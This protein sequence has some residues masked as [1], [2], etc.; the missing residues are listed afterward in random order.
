MA[1]NTGAA[2]EL[3]ASLRQL[4]AD[5]N[6]TT[7]AL[8]ERA[9]ISAANISNYETAAR[10]PSEER[11]EQ[12][13]DALGSN[14]DERE[15][16]LG[17]L[18]KAQ[19]PGNLVPGGTVIG[20]N[21]RQTIDYEENAREII[22]FE[23]GLIPGLLQTPGYA[24][25]VIG[26]SPDASVLVK[27][28]VGRSEILTRSDRPV[29]FLALIDSEVLVRPIASEMVMREQLRHLLKMQARPNVTIQIV[30]ATVRGYHPGL[31]GSF[32]IYRFRRL[33]QWF[34]WRITGP[35][36]FCGT[37]TSLPITSRQRRN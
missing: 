12:L 25:A 28:R 33:H 4:R 14:T 24:R 34:T 17:L 36:R 11:L 21:A 15:R 23:I 20:S 6:L 22:H 16:L 18:R 3:A 26:E 5:A 37:K 35:A 10:L 31:H 27:L 32:K 29:Q 19:G 9:G 7:R 2:T 30:P 8:G 1:S 13:L